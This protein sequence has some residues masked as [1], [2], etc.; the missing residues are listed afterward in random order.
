MASDQSWIS[1]GCWAASSGPTASRAAKAQCGARRVVLR[2]REQGAEAGVAW[3]V[4]GVDALPQPRRQLDS[5]GLQHLPQQ[6]RFAGVVAVE[7]PGGQFRLDPR[8]VERQQGHAGATLAQPVV[9]RL[10]PDLA[11][12]WADGNGLDVLEAGKDFGHR[13]RG[14]G[15]KL[16][17]AVLGACWPARRKFGEK[18]FGEVALAT[19][20]GLGGARRVALVHRRPVRPEDARQAEGRHQHDQAAE[21]RDRRAALDPLDQALDTPDGPGPDRLARLGNAGRSS[22]S[23]SALA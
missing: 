1:T 12:A 5:V 4:G 14:R 19:C 8:L 10:I 7:H 11:Q 22:A 18:F 13:L 6:Q 2:Q 17:D 23:A 21:G 3:R 16:V 15:E 20:L 9:A